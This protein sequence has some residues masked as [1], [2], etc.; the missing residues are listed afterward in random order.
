M[1]PDSCLRVDRENWCQEYRR[2]GSTQFPRKPR[3]LMLC[4][5]RSILR[6]RASG[7]CPTGIRLDLTAD[8]RGTQRSA[9]IKTG[10]RTGGPVH[11]GV[12]NVPKMSQM[13]AKCRSDVQLVH[14]NWK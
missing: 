3:P 14:L 9:R 6:A 2:V 8:Y 11:H 1:L 5:G 10:A 4:G 13:S 12:R 7:D